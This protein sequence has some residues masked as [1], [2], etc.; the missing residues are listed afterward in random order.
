MGPSLAAAPDEECS[1]GTEPAFGW[2]GA[3]AWATQDGGAPRC[4]P[5]GIRE[6]SPAVRAAFGAFWRDEA[7]PDGVGIRTRYTRMV[8][9]VA[10]WFARED[11][12]AGY[13]VMNEPNAFGADELAALGD[14]YGGTIAEIHA[15]ESRARGFSHLVLFEPSIT[16]SDLGV[17]VPPPF[18]HDE[19][20]VFA[21]HIYRGGLTSGPIPSD[22][23]ARAR[24]DAA[25]FGGVPVLVGE[26]G[27]SPA[28]ASD[29]DDV[30]FRRHQALQDEFRF[31]AT[32]WTWRESCGDPHKAVDVRAGRVP[33]V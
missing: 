25:A 30:Y 29:P 11:A 21:P 31:S 12:V 24:H 15:A 5:T 8:G 7:G 32:L 10:E 23:F 1:A 20:V 3:P 33:V 26:W 27:S 16:W 14:L 13:D 22:D 17:G 6:L 28:R 18:A 2:D 19:N 9:H 4:V